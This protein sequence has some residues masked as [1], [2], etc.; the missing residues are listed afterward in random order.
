M[1][2]SRIKAHFD[3][4]A[5]NYDRYKHPGNFYYAE[6]K[7]AVTSCIPAQERVL[8][9]GCG[10]GTLL[11]LTKPKFGLGVDISPQMIKNAQIKYSKRTRISFQTH[12]IESSPL[13]G[14]F[15]YI[16]LA[17][18]IEHLSNPHK[19]LK[20][21]AHSMQ[22]STKLVLTMANPAWE[23]FLMFLENLHFKMPEGPHT[24]ISEKKLLHIFL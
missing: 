3:H 5:P 9:I 10:T 24:R 17:D 6:L 20:N 2:H 23:P 8:E 4:L 11:M 13:P 21:I 1:K 14:K 22:A 16:L 15:D 7:R 19:A 18:V 12:D